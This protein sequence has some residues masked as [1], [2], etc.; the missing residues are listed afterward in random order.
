[1]SAFRRQGAPLAWWG[2]GRTYE[3]PRQA[4][5]AN[6][7]SGRWAALLAFMTGVSCLPKISTT[8]PC[9][10]IFEFAELELLASPAQSTPTVSDVADM[11][12]AR[13]SSASVLYLSIKAHVTPAPMLAKAAGLEVAAF[14]VRRQGERNHI[15]DSELVDRI[16]L[17]DDGLYEWEFL[18]RSSRTGTPD[19]DRRIIAQLVRFVGEERPGLVVPLEE[20]GIELLHRVHHALR[21]CPTAAL[22][23]Y[24][25][26]DPASTLA[27]VQS[28]LAAV[29]GPQDP[30][31]FAA[32][33]YSKT[34]FKAAAASAG[35]SVPATVSLSREGLAGQVDAFAEAHGFPVVVKQAL[36]RSG[37]EGVVVAHDLEAA[38]EAAE[39]F[40]LYVG[41]QGCSFD[42]ASLTPPAL[43]DRAALEYVASNCDTAEGVEA[44]F[45]AHAYPQ[46]LLCDVTLEA[47][48]PGD[49]EGV[50]HFSSF[51]G[52][53]VGAS[54]HLYE[55]RWLGEPPGHPAAIAD[56]QLSSALARDAAQFARHVQFTGVACLN[57][58]HDTSTGV[59][60]F[61]EA[62]SRICGTSND[63]GGPHVGASAWRPLG[64]VLRTRGAMGEAAAR[65]A[66]E[67][68]ARLQAAQPASC[69]GEVR[70]G[71]VDA[72]LAL[73]LG[74]LELSLASPRA[75]LPA[76][77]QTA[78]VALGGKLWEEEP[79]QDPLAPGSPLAASLAGVGA[80]TTSLLGGGL[81]ADAQGVT[82]PDPPSACNDL[83]RVHRMHQRSQFAG[84]R[85]TTVLHT[86]DLVLDLM[87]GGP[88]DP[89]VTRAREELSRACHWP[90]LVG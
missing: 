2:S 35:L 26:L 41:K 32:A 18:G 4:R 23:D 74:L 10:T 12:E 24:L 36:G 72:T 71:G 61:F 90:L 78:L 51:R 52:E 67:A 57:W 58:V 25:G 87:Y 9:N 86:V 46:D 6:I 54:S 63:V 8:A 14:V 80:G 16:A 38:V 88:E 77:P 79:E 43:K 75:C 83:T 62:N 13:A 49:I 47:F 40:M 68:I 89:R 66:A 85:G 30:A 59:V 22:A 11:R 64:D 44:L 42:R 76:R 3:S 1:M 7:S 65:H 60:I 20:P 17:A 45:L 73:D 48:A 53:L 5:R 55:G 31:R 19:D 84:G 82:F 70:G 81:R 28:F 69:T 29:Q 39:A 33:T 50:T 15:E 34:A 37:G 27:D 56:E 21:I